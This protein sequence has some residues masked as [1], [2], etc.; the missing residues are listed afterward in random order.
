MLY[1]VTAS[2]VSSGPATRAAESWTPVRVPQKRDRKNE[3]RNINLTQTSSRWLPTFLLQTLW[4][5]L[6]WRLSEMDPVWGVGRVEQGQVTADTH[7]LHCTCYHSTRCSFIPNSARA[8]CTCTWGA[9]RRAGGTQ[10]LT[11][12]GTALSCGLVSTDPRALQLW[13]VTT[14]FPSPHGGWTKFT[15]IF[16]SR[17][18]ISH[19]PS[20]T[21]S[22]SQT[23][24]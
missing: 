8:C 24:L 3:L 19:P 12:P 20:L 2:A 10:Q 18:N 17:Y 23:S 5:S 21:H 4:P 1:R 6:S 22:F 7:V 14:M 9:F 13:G 11:P 15:L 16:G